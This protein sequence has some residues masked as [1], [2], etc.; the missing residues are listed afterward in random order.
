MLIMLIPKIKAGLCHFI[1]SV[2]VFSGVTLILLY[3][4]YP[5]P[6]FSVSGGWQGLKI[7]A[8]VDLIL[9]PLLTTIIFDLKKP[10]KELVTDISLIVLVQISALVWG[11]YTIYQQRPVALVFWDDG[12]LSVPAI[13]LRQQNIDID[14]LRQFGDT[15]PV[16]VYGKQPRQKPEMEEMLNRIKLDKLPPHHQMALY[17]PLNLHFL[18][19]YNSQV[20]IRKIMSNNATMKAELLPILSEEGKRVDDYQYYSLSSKYY[21]AILLFNRGGQLMNHIIVPRKN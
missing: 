15:F 5:E 20:N 2:L 11:V 6:H 3:F 1:L 10:K 12:F 14:N 21:N 13:A 17:R 8:G 16:L 9:G 18:D 4:W 7:I 19:I